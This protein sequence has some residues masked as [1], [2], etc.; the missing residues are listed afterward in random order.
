MGN[1]IYTSH[2]GTGLDSNLIKEVSNE[3]LTLSDKLSNLHKIINKDEIKIK[4]E[5]KLQILDNIIK[6]IDIEIQNPKNWKT[7]LSYNNYQK[8]EY[9]DFI[10]YYELTNKERKIFDS[11][12]DKQNINSLEYNRPVQIECLKK[13]RELANKYQIELLFPYVNIYES[14][15]KDG[16]FLQCVYNHKIKFGDISKEKIIAL[17]I[18]FKHS[19]K[20][21][22]YNWE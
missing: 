14:W 9:T 3:S 21:E 2:K 8:Y 10:Y 12:I 15:F 11:N 20:P 16:I 17:R 18:V 4:E 1:E 13:C 5:T 19:N 7:G 22:F 6:K